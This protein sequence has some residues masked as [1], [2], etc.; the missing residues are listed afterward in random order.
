MDIKLIFNKFSLWLNAPLL[1]KINTIQYFYYKF[2]TSCFYKHSFRSLGIG[3]VI[4]KPWII[5]NPQYMT[6][7]CNVSIRKGIRLEAVISNKTHLP[8]L[9][10]GDNTNIEQNVHIICHHRIN[11][12]SNVSITGNC[13]IVDTTH[14]YEDINN[15]IKIGARISDNEYSINIGDG[16]FIGFNSMI[17]PNVSIGRYVIIGSHSVVTKDIADYSVAIGSPAKVIKRYNHENGTWEKV[18]Q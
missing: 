8:Y 1:N 11:I 10:I 3:T 14:P 17:L 18:N 5:S 12:G 9:S 4:E 2:I 6:I 7:G 15:P 13:C 16:S